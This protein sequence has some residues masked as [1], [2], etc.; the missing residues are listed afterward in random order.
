MGISVARLAE[1]G[2]LW[3]Q[4]R[5][6]EGEVFDPKMVGELL[7]DL[8]DLARAAGGQGHGLYCWMA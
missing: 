7:R 5:A 8:A 6:A 1:V 3:I 4:E 2:E